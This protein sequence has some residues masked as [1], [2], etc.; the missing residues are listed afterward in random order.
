MGRLSSGWDP[1]SSLPPAQPCPHQPAPAAGGGEGTGGWA[2]EQPGQV[3][4][5]GRPAWERILSTSR[6]L[7][8][9]RGSGSCP[10]GGCRGY[11]YPRPPK[12]PG[13]SPTHNPGPVASPPICNHLDEGRMKRSFH[14]ERQKH[15]HRQAHREQRKE[16]QGPGG[17]DTE[18]QGAGGGP[19][20]AIRPS[21]PGPGPQPPAWANAGMGT[22]RGPGWR[23][24]GAPRGK[25]LS[26]APSR[27]GRGHS[28]GALGEGPTPALHR[29][30]EGSLRKGAGGRQ[31][32]TRRRKRQTERG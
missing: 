6:G 14:G 26:P 7:G 21:P 2:A 20:G 23:G 8:P 28:A 25:A 11:L 24:S 22:G 16:G 15:R 13:R 12:P 27:Q 18:E 30:R 4:S 31:Y 19:G 9:A 10:P 17:E 32:W 5:P 29:E 3:P 1:H